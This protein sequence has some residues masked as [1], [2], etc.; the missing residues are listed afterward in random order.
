MRSDALAE[1]RGAEDGQTGSP[2]PARNLAI[3]RLRG[4]L[5]LLMVGGNFLGGVQAVP[6]FLKH[7]PDIGFTIA[8]TVAPAFGFVIGLNFGPSLARRMRQGVARAYRHFLLRYLALIGI[9]AIL[10]AGQTIVAGEPT[11]WGVLQAIGVAGLL[12]LIVIRLPAW[13]RLGVGLLLLVVYQWLLETRML[14][15]V[16]GSVQGGLFG[17]LSWGALLIL[18]TAVA[19]AWRA[20]WR[21]YGLACAGLA[22]AAAISALLVPV[23]KNRVSLSFVLITLA[24][25]AIVFLAFDLL[26][27]AIPRRPGFLCWWGENALALYLAHLVILGVMMLPPAWWYAQAPLWLAAAQLAVILGALSLLAWWMSARRVTVGL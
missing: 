21:P 12:C 9:G 16:L 11:D 27:R 22:V 18:S 17:T 8:D 10:S 2:P 7:A 14:P 25:A 3:D 5:V 24:I 1:P 15:D 4:V 23:S 19:D 26:S 6:S 13:G 20:G